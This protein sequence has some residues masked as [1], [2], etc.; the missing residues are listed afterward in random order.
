[1][2]GDAIIHNGAD[3]SFLKPYSSL[4]KFNVGSTSELIRLSAPCRIPLHFISSAGV[5]GFVPPELLPL[6]EI[7]VAAYP[8]TEGGVNGYQAA[9]WVSE[10]LL[11]AASE[12]YRMK[13]VIHRPTGIIGEHA[14]NTDIIA[15]FLRYSRAIS[16]APD[17]DNWSGYL[18][19]VD[20]EVVASTISSL[21]TQ[22]DDGAQ[23]SV[24]YI[25]E[26]NDE[27]F[28]IQEIGRYLEM[29]DKNPFEI[30]PMAEW[31]DRA[32]KAGMNEMVCMYLKKTSSQ[33]VGN[34]PRIS[35]RR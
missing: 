5:A 20:V 12:K 1:M 18:D 35:S 13:V 10:R 25:H 32:G 16:A 24:T 30:L 19:L 4:K 22:D 7:S 27:S 31:I 15:N 11:E 26:C 33:G 28:P 14:S 3:V 21:T 23:P 17:M 2:R 8:P 9:K 29:E 34:Y 6:K